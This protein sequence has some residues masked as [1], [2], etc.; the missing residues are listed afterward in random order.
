MKRGLIFF[1]LLVLSILLYGQ[2]S[3]EALP[4]YFPKGS[5][6]LRANAISGNLNTPIKVGMQ[7]TINGWTN[8][9]NGSGT[10][11]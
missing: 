1:F 8:S 2:S 11:W 10:A 7:A 9:P 3:T 4:T 6:S 5:L